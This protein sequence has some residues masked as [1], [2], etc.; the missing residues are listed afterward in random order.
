[1]DGESGQNRP[2]NQ[3]AK[4]D[5]P[6]SESSGGSPNLGLLLRPRGSKRR[7]EDELCKILVSA[8]WQGRRAE[9]EL[10]NTCGPEPMEFQK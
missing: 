9:D 8:R 10:C 7:A 1:M 4:K 5:V 6:I 3:T 2:K